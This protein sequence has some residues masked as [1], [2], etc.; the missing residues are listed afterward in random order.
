MWLPDSRLDEP[1]DY[2]NSPLD[3]PLGRVKIDWTHPATRSLKAYYIFNFAHGL[4]DLVTGL[5]PPS[6]GTARIEQVAGY[7]G[8]RGEGAIGF[9]PAELGLTGSGPRSIFMEVVRIGS[10]G[11]DYFFL[12]GTTGYDGARHAIWWRQS[13]GYWRTETWGSNTN[14]VMDTSFIGAPPLNRRVAFTSRLEGGSGWLYYSENAVDQEAFG[15]NTAAGANV[16]FGVVDFNDNYLIL[17]AAITSGTAL[18][19]FDDHVK[20]FDNPY[21]FL[22]PE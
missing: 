2:F 13:E 8:R 5:R 11:N 19:T 10:P 6:P 16:N 20:R 9:S 4:D 1:T 21:E 14:R 22:I 12:Y 7:V 17:S 15:F 18:W 3:K